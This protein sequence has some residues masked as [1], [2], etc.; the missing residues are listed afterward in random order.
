LQTHGDFGAV[1]CPLGAFEESNIFGTWQELNIGEHYCSA[2]R[3]LFLMYLFLLLLFMSV[4]EPENTLTSTSKVVL[5]IIWLLGGCRMEKL[6]CGW[7]S[8][9]LDHADTCWFVP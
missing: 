4:Y 3:Y 2:K 9:V 1:L 8:Q 6:N 5:S 7:S